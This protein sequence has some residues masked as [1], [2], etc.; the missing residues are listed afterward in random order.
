MPIKTIFHSILAPVLVHV[1]SQ[2]LIPYHAPFLFLSFLRAHFLSIF[3][4]HARSRVHGLV[5]FLFPLFLFPFLYFFLYL[6][7]VFNQHSLYPSLYLSFYLLYFLLHYPPF[8]FN[9]PLKH[10]DLYLDLFSYFSL[11][12][13]LKTINLNQY[14][15]NL[16]FF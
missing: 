5:G 9:R 2:A 1:L 11:I 3:L 13:F 15:M 8:S 14:L 10:L 4:F 7:F 12:F 16:Y 6:F